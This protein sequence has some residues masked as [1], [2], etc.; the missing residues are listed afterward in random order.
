MQ[1]LIPS[2]DPNTA[3]AILV[4]QRGHTRKD[5]TTGIVSRNTNGQITPRGVVARDIAELR[6]VY[7]D[8][9]NSQL[10]E[11]IRANKA[12]YPDAFKKN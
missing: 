5:L 6:R 9:P 11:L 8:V 2:Y 10:Q 1:K 4:P 3:P 12:S 7:P